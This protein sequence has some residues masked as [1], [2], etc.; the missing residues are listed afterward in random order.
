MWTCRVCTLRNEPSTPRCGACST[1]REATLPITSAGGGA[2]GAGAGA[3]ASA[4]PQDREWTG[5]ITSHAVSRLRALLASSPASLTPPTWALSSDADHYSQAA[6]G[7]ADSWSCGFRNI[8]ILCSALMTVPAYRAVLFGGRGV[9]PSVRGLQ[10]WIEAAWARGYDAQG[11]QQLGWKLVGSTKWIGSAECAALL[12][13][14]G[15]PAAMVGFHALDD[16]S[17]ANPAYRLAPGIVQRVQAARVAADAELRRGMAALPRGM[18]R[19]M[20]QL[21]L[22]VVA[23]S[24]APAAPPSRGGLLAAEDIA[25]QAAIA[26][27]MG[28]EED[29]VIL[30]ENEM[31]EDVQLVEEEG[32]AGGGSTPFNG[33]AAGSAA[34][35]PLLGLAAPPAYSPR[36]AP[37]HVPGR[38]ALAARH[39]AL[40]RWL[41]RHFGAGM[42]AGGAPL[43]SSHAGVAPFPVFL[44]H[45]GHSR[46]CVGYEVRAA[47]QGVAPGSAHPFD[48]SAEVSVLLLDPA[49]PPA[50][51]EMGLRSDTL[52]SAWPRVFKRG[53]HT[54][55][56]SVYEAVVVHRGAAVVPGGVGL[57]SLAEVHE[58][59]Q[60]RRSAT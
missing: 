9:V 12:R 45:D 36:T 48:G 44:Q 19:D 18:G 25:L 24:P 42:Q 38:A 20:S 54:L 21:T 40:I 3:S 41:G 7:R 17:I 58:W 29:D 15:I 13:S 23:P 8:Q 16:P 26:A 56:R 47:S 52:P 39:E 2:S 5:R 32:G 11:A 22:A 55:R 10:G 43:S 37:T 14:F 4:D 30:L 31:D 46:T 57:Q 59:P 35:A 34:S 6:P 50:A 27:S 1:A 53:L 33:T 51:I 28:L 49:A 60:G